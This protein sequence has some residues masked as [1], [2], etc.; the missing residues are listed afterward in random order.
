MRL[1]RYTIAGESR[2]HVGV[3]TPEG[4]AS[5]DG[6]EVGG[7]PITTIGQA[8]ASAMSDPA[9]LAG[10]SA[11]HGWDDIAFA[12]P[13]DPGARMLCA[14]ANYHKKYP[15]GGNVQ[16]PAQPV[17]FNKPP[18][19]LVAH[20][21]HLIRPSVSI[22]FDYE[23]ELAV[24]IGRPGR[25][26]EEADALDYVGGY[27]ILNDGSVRDWQRHSVAAGKNFF[28]S[29]SLG[30]WITTADE[31]ADPAALE[32]ICRVNG[33]ERQRAGVSEMIFSVAEIVS[34]L[35]KVMPLE[36]GDIIA[37]GSPE[38]TGGSFEPPLWLEPGD[39]IAFEIPGIGVLENRVIDE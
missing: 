8:V 10:A 26:I 25:H 9:A 1:L 37:T 19:T 18:G 21:E 5:L 3:A 31:I 2:T 29:G 39:E 32:V 7:S 17:Y 20:G 27:S 11:D 30:P 15:L 6:V 38:G 34:Y 22:Q 13:A 24:V 4:V 33:S 28:R 16:A 14:G 35:S 36:P 12:V 23:V